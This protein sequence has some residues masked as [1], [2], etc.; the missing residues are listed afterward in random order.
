V[1]RFGRPP[2]T[3]NSLDIL[4]CRIIVDIRDEN[5]STRT[6]KTA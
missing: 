3:P 1:T 5:T 4:G 2:R 6:C